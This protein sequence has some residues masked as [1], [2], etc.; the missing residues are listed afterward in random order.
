MGITIKAVRALGKRVSLGTIRER[1]HVNCETNENKSC[2]T[3]IS[4]LLIYSPSQLTS[5]GGSTGM[6]PKDSCDD[7]D[8]C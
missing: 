5:H 2:R 4:G 3:Q 8:D 1:I 7:C 6:H